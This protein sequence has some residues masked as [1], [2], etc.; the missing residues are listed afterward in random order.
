MNQSEQSVAFLHEDFPFGGGEQVTLNLASYFGQNGYTVHVFAMRLHPELQSAGTSLGLQVHQLPDNKRLDSPGNLAA[1]STALHEK[2]IRLLISTYTE[3]TAFGDLRRDNPHC[4]FIYVQHNQPLW[5][6]RNKEQILQGKRETRA[7]KVKWVFVDFL[8]YRLLRRHYAHCLT[9]YRKL[10]RETDAFVVLCPEYKD[11][12]ARLLRL[13]EPNRLH[14][15]GNSVD[16]PRHPNLQKAR[17]VLYAGRMDPLQKR[18]DR[19]LRIWRKVEDE[20][21]GWRLVLA[22]DGPDLPRL[23]EMA[24]SLG[25]ERASFVGY[26]RDM[27]SYYEQSAAICLTSS[28]EGWPL[29][30]AE[31]QAYGVVPVAFDC[32]GGIRFLCGEGECG[33]LAPPFDEDAYARNLIRLLRDETLRGALQQKGLLKARSYSLGQVG[34]QWVGL[35]ETLLGTTKTRFTS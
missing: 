18:V 12:M 11:E 3:F 29:C 17:Q 23:K 28:F 22:G 21:P 34:A 19:L 9:T 31:A 14:A 30:L 2:D 33:V 32:C 24:K 25:L 6:V 4:R 35:F 15:I 26:Q 20:L 10:Y 1:L 27:A 13:E 7:G 16:I 8:K 5:E